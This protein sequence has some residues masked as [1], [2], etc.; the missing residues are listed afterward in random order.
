MLTVYLSL[1]LYLGCYFLLVGWIFLSSGCKA[2]ILFSILRSKTCLI[3]HQHG[4]IHILRDMLNLNFFEG[5]LHCLIILRWAKRLCEK[6]G[7]CTLKITV[8]L[9]HAALSIW[10]CI[11]RFQ[12]A[13]WSEINT[14]RDCICFSHLCWLP[15][16][17]D[18]WQHPPSIATCIYRFTSFILSWLL[19]N[20]W[21]WNITLWS[22]LIK[23][24]KVFSDANEPN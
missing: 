8:I 6:L 15:Q 19:A 9:Y 22:I 13:E 2:R 7:A 21:E 11:E 5:I 24:G 17:K 23:S 20:T 3:H 16:R 18:Q 1:Y 10:I 4:T 12:D 14:Q